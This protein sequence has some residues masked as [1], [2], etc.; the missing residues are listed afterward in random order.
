MFPAEDVNEILYFY[1]PNCSQCREATESL[2]ILDNKFNVRYIDG[3][4]NPELSRKYN[5]EF[6]PTVIVLDNKNNKLEYFSGAKKIINY[7]KKIFIH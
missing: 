5:I 4:K 6:Y 3:D 2:K 1:S 7:V